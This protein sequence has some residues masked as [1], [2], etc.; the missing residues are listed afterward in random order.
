M[1]IGIIG[2]GRIASGVGQRLVKAGHAVYFGSRDPGKAAAAGAQIGAD[3]GSQ[4]DAA[5]F[6]EVIVLAVPFTSV[7]EVSQTLH[8]DGKIV[9]ETTND[10]QGGGGQSST[11]R[12]QALFPNARVVKA[13][14]HIFAQI[15]AN[16]PAHDLERSTAFIAGD[17]AAAKATAAGIIESMNFDVVDVGGAKNAAHLDNLVRFVIEMGYGLGM[18]PNIAFKLV[19][20]F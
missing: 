9:I 4:A 8:L 18:G 19:K 6:G 2:T 1:K 7:E 12:V 15:L 16:D 17:D 5:A 11:E 20:V 10:L 3:G 13:F 14:N